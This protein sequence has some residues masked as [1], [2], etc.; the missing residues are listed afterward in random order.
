MGFQYTNAYIGPFCTSYAQGAAGDIQKFRFPVPVLSREHVAQGLLITEGEIRL[1]WSD[2]SFDTTLGPGGSFPL[3]RPGIPLAINAELTLTAL[4]RAAYLCVSAV[5]IEQKVVLDRMSLKP[6][7]C[8]SIE[9]YALLAICGPEAQVRI[10][11]GEAQTGIRLAYA[12]D[13]E[14]NVES[15]TPTLLGKFSFAG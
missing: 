2:R 6:G 5:G 14:L 10:N 9:R 11:G 13:G 7:E 8:V 3:D 15:L 4:S 1:N 12:R